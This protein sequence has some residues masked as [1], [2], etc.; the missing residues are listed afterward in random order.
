MTEILATAD[1]AE[2]PSLDVRRAIEALRNGV[3]N[4]P[5]V[6]ALGCGQDAVEE[7]F[8][9]GLAATL[10]GVE[11]GSQ[12]QGLLVAGGF[13]TGK[14][15][16]LEYLQDLALTENFVCSRVVISKETPL[17]DPA[18][19]YKAAVEAAEVPGQS[20]QAIQEI[21]VRLKQDSREYVELFEWA[22][23][24]SSKISSVF[25]ATL[26]IHER[27]RSNPDAVEEIRNFWSG[28]PL[29]MKK[30]RDNLKEIKQASTFILK[31]F[32]ARELARQRFAFA[33][34]LMRGAGY[35]GWVLLIDEVELISRYPLL[36]R[37]RSYA[38]LAR[39]MSALQGEGHPAIFAVAAITDDFDL[40]VLKDKGDRDYVG[41]RLRAKGTA[42]ADALAAAAEAG[43]RII[44]RSAVR[45]SP[46]N[47]TTL[48]MT[49]ETLKRMHGGAYSWTP[50][51]VSGV[52][53]SSRRAMRSH[54]RRWINEWDL[55]RLYPQAEIHT[56]EET[57]NPSY[58]EDHDL[59]VLSTEV[60]DSPG[61]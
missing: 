51:D 59:D 5:A 61:E 24:E 35:S 43:M 39:W 33:P 28:E 57:L 2:P 17:Y 13:G 46:P 55:K 21:G 9:A 6:R 23:Q 8:R 34:R 37:G 30:I 3:P 54:V 15:H 58:D 10:S 32:P 53:Q 41:P 14:S 26:L 40:A 48:D 49:Y 31:S 47:Q 16:L 12:P 25:P 18:K 19:V 27:L 56:E 11:E 38:E 52:A 42:E 29:A 20:G 36:Q 60:G 45:L 44:E 4:R 22:N 7:R 50:P 1:T